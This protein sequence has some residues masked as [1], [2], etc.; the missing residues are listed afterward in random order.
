MHGAFSPRQRSARVLRPET[1]NREASHG[2]FMS[3]S[4]RGRERFRVELSER[5]LGFVQ[6]P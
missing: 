4:P 5:L 2:E 6:A 1:A 3:C